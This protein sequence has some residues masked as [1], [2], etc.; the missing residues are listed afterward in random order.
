M[1]MG[2]GSLNRAKHAIVLREFKA[3]GTRFECHSYRSGCRNEVPTHP[4]EGPT[5]RPK[6]PKVPRSLDNV[7]VGFK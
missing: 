3:G 2:H 4:S 6:C 7:A 5:A 1:G